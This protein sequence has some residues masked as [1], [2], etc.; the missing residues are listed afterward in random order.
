MNGWKG[1]IGRTDGRKT[2]MNREEWKEEEL[3]G[4]REKV[5]E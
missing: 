1:E 2:A 4:P 5:M 3:D